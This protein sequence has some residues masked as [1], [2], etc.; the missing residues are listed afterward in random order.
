MG[1]GCAAGVIVKFQKVDVLTVATNVCSLPI[2]VTVELSHCE[3][4]NLDALAA[5]C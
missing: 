1:D 5:E 4:I 2:L 3:G